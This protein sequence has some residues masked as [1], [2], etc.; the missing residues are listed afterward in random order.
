MPYPLNQVLAETIE[1]R[2]DPK[3][4]VYAILEILKHP[5]KYAN[6]YNVIYFGVGLLQDYE[7]YFCEEKTGDKPD[8]PDDNDEKTWLDLLEK[9]TEWLRT[10]DAS[11]TT[12]PFFDDLVEHFERGDWTPYI[13]KNVMDA[14]CEDLKELYQAFV[15]V[16]DYEVLPDDLPF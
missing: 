10:L 13:P 7:Y 8:A 12:C 2:F 3:Y 16:S 11:K 14:Y 5:V 4:N 6:I 1:K 9:D 15:A